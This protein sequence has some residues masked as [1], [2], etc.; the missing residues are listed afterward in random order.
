MS[1]VTNGLGAVGGG[2]AL[3]ENTKNS[4]NA[5]NS[6][7]DDHGVPTGPRWDVWEGIGNAARGVGSM[8]GFG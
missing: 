7:L 3:A 1:G 6:T 4:V 8:L 2:A 5:I